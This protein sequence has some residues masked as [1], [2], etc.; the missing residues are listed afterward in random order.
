MDPLT[1]LGQILSLGI[2]AW[3]AYLCLA[4]R[5][6]RLAERRESERRGSGGRRH[7]DAMATNEARGLFLSQRHELAELALKYYR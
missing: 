1:I 5:E 6:R 2:L 7:T 4:K 3:G